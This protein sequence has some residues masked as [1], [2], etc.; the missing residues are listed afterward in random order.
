MA[1]AVA[2]IPFIIGGLGVDQ[3]GVLTLAWLVIGYFGLFDL[4]LGWALTKLVSE[5]LGQARESEI[6]EIIW[7]SMAIMGVLGS[8]GALIMGSLSPWLV[9]SVFKIP[10]ALQA[11]SLNVFLLLA[12]CIPVVITTDGLRGVLEA[13][14]RFGLVNALRIPLGV[15][16]YVG[17]MLVLLVS[18]SLFYV[19]LAL[20]VGRLAAWLAHLVICIKIV[21]E[22]KHGFKVRRKLMWPLITF[23]SWMTVS[24]II[25][26]IITYMDRF[27]IGGLLSMSAVAYYATPFEMVTKLWTIPV[28][29]VGVVFPALSYVL[30]R[31][32]RE[33][34]ERIFAV[35]NK[36]I[37]ISMFPICFL[38]VVFSHEGLNLWL[39]QEFADNSGR[40]LQIL[41][42]G[43]FINSIARISSALIQAMGRPDI[44]SKIS[45][46]EFP[47][48]VL[49]LYLFVS[50]FGVVGAAAA[51]LVKNILDL[52]AYLIMAVIIY[53]GLRARIM[54]SVRM[55]IYCVA[56]ILVPFFHEFSM[57]QK[58]ILSIIVITGFAGI[59]W[60][61]ILDHREKNYL[62][63][64]AKLG[65]AP[66]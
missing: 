62:F 1:V 2:A 28:A 48:F 44:K 36:Y 11:E 33:D 54:W 49:I 23:G 21:P 3:F 46:A 52:F 43:V 10:E 29:L 35:S 5:R 63:S 9:H 47:V 64:L 60:F 19:V 56:V 26:P 6:P 14:Q 8:V 13:H 65:R 39:G 12:V 27:L 66:Q 34:V 4:G 53:P 7:T 37:F 55:A 24:N 40:I 31:E 50:R 45:L 57:M 22:L 32:D 25:G 15:F 51:F 41:T 30:A 17:P 42:L 16:T 20:V 38:L 61:R 18:D 59:I 58:V